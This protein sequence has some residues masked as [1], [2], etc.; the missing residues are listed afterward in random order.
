MRSGTM[1]TAKAQ[2]AKVS[3]HAAWYFSS[4]RVSWKDA[5][6]FSAARHGSESMRCPCGS[7]TS[8]RQGG[9]KGRAHALVVVSERRCLIDE[10][11]ELEYE[12]DLPR[13]GARNGSS[14]THGR[15]AER[16]AERFA[17]RAGDWWD[18]AGESGGCED[19]RM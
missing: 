14:I 2:M 12:E 16:F 15:A 8:E 3:M 17:E 9:A 5:S 10:V 4:T 6:S 13:G 19:V 1:H 7:R 18:G 11:V